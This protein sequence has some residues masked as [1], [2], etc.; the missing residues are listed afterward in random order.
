MMIPL[1]MTLFLE[2]ERDMAIKRVLVAKKKSRFREK[3]GNKDIGS[4][5]NV[6]VSGSEV[7]NGKVIDC[8][9]FNQLNKLVRVTGF[10]LRYVHNVKAF[11]S[12]CEVAKA[13]LLFDETEKSKLICVKHEQCFIKNSENY[14][15]L[16]NQ[17]NLIIDSGEV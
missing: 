3:K 16:K 5:V 7:G 13:D 10:V 12:G 9:R 11:L 8:G 17:L 4:S 2:W 14:S 15:K 1:I 6:N